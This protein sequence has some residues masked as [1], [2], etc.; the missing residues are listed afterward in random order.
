MFVDE[1]LDF[2][3]KKSIL[4]KRGGIVVLRGEEDD[5]EEFEVFLREV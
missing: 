5:K 1:G 3:R 2:G 4:D